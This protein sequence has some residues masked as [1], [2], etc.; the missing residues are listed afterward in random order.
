MALAMRRRL[1]GFLC[2]W[3]I[4][5][6]LA[7]SHEVAEHFRKAYS[8]RQIEVLPN[9][10]DV[11]AL[12]TLVADKPP[13]AALDSQCSIVLPG[14]IVPEKGH[15]DLIEALVILKGKGLT[16]AVIIAGDGPLRSNVEAQVHTLGLTDHVTFT[17]QQDHAALMAIMADAE[18]VVVPS[19]FEG[20]GLT[21]LE[22]MT[23]GR[24]V[25]GSRAGGLPETI[26]GAGILVPVA[27]PAAL[28]QALER[29]AHDPDLRAR[30]GYEAACRAATQFVLPAVSARLITIYAG[31]LGTAKTAPNRK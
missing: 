24:A 31:L 18:I 25:V 1:A 29:L 16:P 13:S 21:A 11:A 19:R 17:G 12:R 14:R 28:A 4:D 2:R 10:V 22:A 27:D 7:V 6:C 20:F 26:G 30:L 9:P 3:G 15:A 8:L 23:L 5:Q